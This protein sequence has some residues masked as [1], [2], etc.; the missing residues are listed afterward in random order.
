MIVLQKR[1]LKL[2]YALNLGR[3]LTIKQIKAY[4][5][6]NAS[7]VACR[8]RLGRLASQRFVKNIQGKTN[9]LVGFSQ[10]VWTLDS[11][12]FKF[13]DIRKR[14]VYA[15][16][17][18]ISHQLHLNDVMLAFFHEYGDQSILWNPDSSTRYDTQVGYFEPDAVLI[19]PLNEAKVFFEFDNGTKYT[20][21]LLRNLSKYWLWFSENRD[22]NVSLHYSVN[23]NARAYFIK[24]ALEKMYSKYKDEYQLPLTIKIPFSISVKEDSHEHLGQLMFGNQVD[25]SAQEK[26]DQVI[27]QEDVM[28]KKPKKQAISNFPEWV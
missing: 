8:N 28:M 1:D 20:K 17:F 21:A 19:N 25:V 13:L 2:L 10:G 14:G 7:K 27:N 5:F 26:L 12:G 18:S 4:L 6:S 23:S 3:V 15:S 22:E 16:S 11:A 9:C 24:Q